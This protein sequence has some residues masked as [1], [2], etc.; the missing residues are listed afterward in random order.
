MARK[1]NFSYVYTGNVCILIFSVLFSLS[2]TAQQL[3]ISNFVLFGGNGQ[4]PNGAGQKLPAAPG[5]GVIL[6]SSTTIQDGSI[7][8]YNL[9]T[10]TG[11][12]TISSNLYCGGSIQLANSNVVTGNI[13][14]A[15]NA[16]IAGTVL[17]VGSGAAI[18]GNIDV[19][20]NIVI[21]GGSVNGKVTHPAGT[22]YSGP[23]PSGGNI[24]GTPALPVLPDMPAITNFPAVGSL[25]ISNNISIT[26]GAY[27][28]VTLGGNKTLTFS[29]PGVYV[30]NSIKNSGTTN[31]F[32]FDFQN[33]TT[34]TFKIYVY[35][36]VDVNKVLATMKNG[37]NANRIYCETHGNGSSSS[38][39][40][41]AWNIANGSAGS[42]TKWLGSVWAPYA[43]IN[44]GAGTGS[45]DLTGALWSG[46]QVNVKSGVTINFAPFSF[47]NP[48]DANAGIDK[49]LN[50]STLTTLTGTSTT[51]GVSYSWQAINGGI[52]SSPPNAAVITVSVADTYILTV[53]SAS[54]C[55]SKDSVVVSSRLKSL[56]G[57]ELQSIYDNNTSDTTFFAIANGY[58][59][60]DVIALQG[61]RDSVLHLLQND[62]THY[63]LRNI[64]PNGTNS[65]ILTGEYPI[66]HLPNLNSLFTLIKYC[67]PYY[68]AVN[69]AGLVAT[70]GD[71]TIRSYL[72]RKGYKID[73]DGIKVGVISDSYA[74]ITSGTTAS[75]PLQSVTNPP[76]PIL[77]TF[78]TNTAAQDVANG[79]L[80]GDTTF[81]VGGHVVNPNGYNKNVHVL[82][83]FPV[84]RTDEG[85]AMLQIL[86]DVAPGAELYFRTGFFT[87]GDFAS[88]IYQLKDAGC[89]VI[90]DDVTFITEPFLKDGVVAKAV[91]SV[92]KQGVAYF[93]AAGNFSN[94]SYEKDFNPITVPAG[95]FAGKMAHNFGGGD[96]FQHVKL[97]P[98]NYTIVF[99]WTD[100][101]YS[102]GETGGTKNDMDI[103]LTPATDGTALYGFNRDNTGGDPIEF[104]PFTIPGTDSLETNVF[105]VNNTTT[106]NP[107][108]IKYIVF[109]GG[110]R[111]MEFNEGTSTLVGQAN[112]DSAIAVGAARFDKA[113]PY[114]NPPLI[115][116]YS[117]TGGTKTNGIIRNKPDLVAPD[118]VNTTVR[119]GQDYPN[120]ALDGFSNFF[121]TSAAAPHAAAIAALIMQGKKKFLNQPVTTPSEIRS[122]LQSTATDMGTPGFDFSSGYGLVNV[123]LSMRTFAAPTPNINELIVPLTS[124]LTIPGHAVLTVTVKGENF[125]NNSMLYFRDSALAST[126]VLNTNEATAV[127]PM[128]GDNPPIR[129]YTPPYPSTI[130]VNGKHLDGGFSNSLYFF[131]GDITVNAVSLTKK[132]G[133]QVPALDTVIK[134]NGVLMQDTTLTLKD[135]GLENMTLTTSATIN[136]DVGTYIITPSRI[137]DQTNPLDIA[138]LKKYNYTF[139]PG[140]LTVEKMPLKVTPE[141]KTITYGQY[142]GNI[143]FKYEFNQT[144][145]PDPTA[146][147]NLI[148]T[149]H[150]GYVPNNAL[151]IVKGFSKTQADGSVLTNADLLNMNMIASF[152]AVK[153]SG[154]FQVD[155]NN[156]LVSLS[157][158]NTF[159]VQYMVDIASESIYNYKK[160]PSKAKFFNVYPGINS[161]AVLGETALDNGTGKVE[162]NGSLVQM[163]NGS[164]VQMVNGTTGPMVPIVNGSLVQ[165]L[166]GSL[167]Q[168]INGVYVTIPNG[169][170]VQ[171]L[172]GS[173]VQLLN[174]EYVTIPNGSL[175]QLLNGTLVQLLNGSLV[176][177]L[178]GVATPIINGSL[179]QLLN[180]SLV[181]L[182]NGVY[183]PIPNGSLVQLLNGSLVQLLNGSLV[184]LLN[185]SLVQLLNSSS[186]QFVNGS[187]VQLL[188]GNTIG[189]GTLNNNTAV[190]IDEYDVNPPSNWL[191]SMFG[192]NMITGL[193][194][195]QQS[196][197]P[198]VLVNPNFDI[199]YGLGK[200]TINNNPCVITHSPFKN[201][202]NTPDPQKPTSLWVN[203]VIKIS[204]QLNSKG[205]YLLFKSGKISLTNI[206]SNPLITDLSI[207]AGKIV[208]DNVTV[209]FAIYDSVHNMWITKVPLG[210]ASTSDIF[211]TGAIINS[212]TGF[213]KDSSNTYSVVKGIFYSNKNFTDQWGYA[214]AA[215]QPEFFYASISDSGKVTSING[216]YRAG[217]PT[218]QI[219]NIVQGGSGGG[220]GNNYTGS[221]S[222]YDKF[223]ACVLASS[224]AV[225]KVSNLNQEVVQNTPSEGEFQI[226]PNPASDYITISFVNARTGNSKIILFTIDGKK[227]FETDNGICEAGKKYIKKIDVSKLLSGV[228]LAQLWSTDKK[229]IKK[230]IISR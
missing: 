80:P 13:T 210:F 135:I 25:N 216:T 140:T 19:K 79:D 160:D 201:F 41:V 119:S 123:D 70:A 8:S 205:D 71:T 169:S 52:I 75:L 117:S 95:V 223:T 176:Q 56:I 32:V 1:N 93:S 27:G 149:Y 139:T 212:S 65:F 35:G 94:K 111:I 161:K 156:E 171:I 227:I 202:G 28:N 116:S 155:A 206:T 29:G 24:I 81:L 31:N 10:S 126:V 109:R 174:G 106:S 38:N 44:I 90:V 77:Q 153:N 107:S 142:L 84:R 92:V 26:P 62:T 33:T 99:Q 194:V 12:S 102:F 46:T 105:I 36:D 199:T 204:G 15:N 50:F 108:R 55:F 221:S 54:N 215:Y 39:G 85:R 45:S 47:C 144:N 118:G 178:N 73:G 122:L 217:T 207:P 127:V 67:R 72:V 137:F 172:N 21:S 120:S 34:G 64:I 48:P 195:G 181:Q 131:D 104:I 175:V 86:H 53:S 43:S 96:I 76:N 138:L 63:G 154:K 14:V 150:Q 152:Q 57:S 114:L 230:I 188:N 100:G 37:G 66:R 179:V 23:V 59:M 211:V 224:P 11:N 129:L 225:S 180:G 191:G 124:P 58:V 74:T 6:G 146:L 200:V 198:G 219:Q 133:Q 101:I 3:N 214:T 121:G 197:I 91:D 182:L 22:T 68:Q 168:L 143:T 20:G 145:V 151:A 165:I 192:I 134:I 209:P 16:N 184:Q 170:L 166:N 185:G 9:I 162:V 220:G 187:L 5:C 163:L 167:V 157:N 115:E 125:S 148:K 193:D 213:V 18:T 103:Y 112:A 147:L 78:T 208:A 164:L 203:L 159:N 30:F 186:V 61:Y 189:A 2:V 128:F 42:T 228:Y 98:G 173:L 89:K 177:L 40:T 190:I 4:C 69:N 183:V 87:P 218:T 132:Y 51:A 82:Q 130:L 83:D 222:S 88:G 110:V 113:P 158:P 229:N 60:I 226:I 136:S 97:A 7:G 49:P 17:S 141:D 196:L